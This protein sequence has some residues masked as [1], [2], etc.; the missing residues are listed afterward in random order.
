VKRKGT[1]N[2]EVRARGKKAP[3]EGG[4]EGAPAES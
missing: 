2:P 3:E 1:G 4:G